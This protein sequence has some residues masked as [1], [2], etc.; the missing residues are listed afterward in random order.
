[1][2]LR[3]VYICMLSSLLLFS[4]PENK[5]TSWWGEG[6]RAVYSG[7]V[8][9][10][11]GASPQG[12]RADEIWAPGQGKEA[13][14][15]FPPAPSPPPRPSKVDKVG[16]VPGALAPGLPTPKG[17]KAV[18]P[19]QVGPLGGR[20]PRPSKGPNARSALP[21]VPAPRSAEGRRAGRAP[22]CRQPRPAVPGLGR[23][24]RQPTRE[25]SRTPAPRPAPG[26]DV[27]G[28]PGGARAGLGL[29]L[30]GR[31]R[32]RRRQERREPRRRLRTLPQDP[33]RRRAAP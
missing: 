24:P 19:T 17:R 10:T 21:G 16:A 33:G 28:R 5:I 27:T 18:P 4:S 14:L 11:Q 9:G 20:G 3:A 30:G 31:K 25:P 6:R 29:G 22:P 23:R 13:P 12:E 2:A 32:R 26:A 1:M 8:R 7:K 15:C